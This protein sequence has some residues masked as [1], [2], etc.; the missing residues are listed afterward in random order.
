MEKS[1][2]QSTLVVVQFQGFSL[3][4]KVFDNDLNPGWNEVKTATVAFDYLYFESS[5]ITSLIS[6]VHVSAG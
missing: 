6:V 5:Y 2:I 1:G 3:K 4:S